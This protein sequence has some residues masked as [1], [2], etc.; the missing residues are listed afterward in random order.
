MKRLIIIL[1]TLG[2]FIPSFGQ[3][4]ENSEIN[5]R[6]E[7]H[8]Y[9]KQFFVNVKRDSSIFFL[10]YKIRQSDNNA[11][12]EKNP[13]TIRLREDFLK[14]KNVSPTNDSLIKVLDGLDSIYLAFTTFRSDS[15]ILSRKSFPEFDTL[16]DK[17]FFTPTDSLQN[18]GHIYLD[19]TSFVFR[20]TNKGGTRKVYANSINKNNHL[21]L[22]EFM[23][24]TME[25]YRNIKKNDFLDRKSTAGY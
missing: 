8:T 1:Y 24:V 15:L 9:Y 21:Q 7:N 5:I 16:M 17:L 19:G 2:T 18:S 14:I 12:R 3:N 20:L 22:A 23:A 13:T 11:E 10:E 6:V 25:L 4:L